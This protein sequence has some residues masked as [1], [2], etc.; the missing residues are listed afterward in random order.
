MSCCG[1]GFGDC[2]SNQVGLVNIAV[3]YGLETESDVV[4]W[5][6]VEKFI[7]RSESYL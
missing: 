2:S 6:L 5:C 7:I 4:S 1:V 3:I